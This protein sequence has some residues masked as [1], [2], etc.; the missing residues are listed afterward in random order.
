MDQIN[1][2]M[3]NNKSKEKINIDEFFPLLFP[4]YSPESIIQDPCQNSF[5]NNIINENI[6]LPI[7]NIKNIFQKESL[8]LN[9]ADEEDTKM[10]LYFIKKQDNLETESR[11]TESSTNVILFNQKYIEN[12]K[13][14]TILKKNKFQTFLK[15]KR[16]KKPKLEN[17]KTSKKSHGSMDFDNIQRKIQV[18]FFNFLISLANDKVEQIFGKK[19]KYQ[20]KDVKYELKRIVNHKNIEYLKGCKY[21]D[22][23]K[24][25]ISPKNKKFSEDTNK[26]IYFKITQLSKELK[27]FFDLNYLYIFQKYYF[28]L[29]PNEK[30][31][32][33]EGKIIPLSLKTKGFYNLLEKNKFSK[34]FNDIIKDVYFTNTNYLNDKKFMITNSFNGN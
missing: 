26:N 4:E 25:K 6:L 29:K 17:L 23:I 10:S 7:E 16:G 13:E 12:K 19:S 1:K 27:D 5:N 3:F 30:D 18:H 32:N 2:I 8:D 33:F 14:T 34:K 15:K 31:I 28:E 9:E 24:M 21:S 11:S 20:F 22:I